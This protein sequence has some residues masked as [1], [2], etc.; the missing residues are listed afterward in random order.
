MCQEKENNQRYPQKAYKKGKGG[1][2]F[3]KPVKGGSQEPQGK[4]NTAMGYE[5]TRRVAPQACTASVV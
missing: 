5:N 1:V 2:P 3:L 4:E